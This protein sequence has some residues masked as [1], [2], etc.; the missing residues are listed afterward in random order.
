MLKGSRDEGPSQELGL[1]GVML[2]RIPHKIFLC[3][4]FTLTS[5]L[6]RSPRRALWLGM[7][8]KK[9]NI[10]VALVCGCQQPLLDDPSSLYPSESWK[11]QPVRP[12]GRRVLKI[13]GHQPARSTPLYTWEGLDV[14]PPDRSAFSKVKGPFL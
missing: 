14:C 4:S 12:Q 3:F 1:R 5:A 13:G 8:L 11:N 9:E 10:C 2:E 7:S 6:L